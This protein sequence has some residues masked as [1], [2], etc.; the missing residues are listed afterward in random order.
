MGLTVVGTDIAIAHVSDD[1]PQI[2]KGDILKSMNG[3]EIT[4]MN[5]QAQFGAFHS[6]KP[7]DSVSFTFLRDGEEIDVELVLPAREIKHQFKV[8]EKPK[9]KQLKLREKWL[10]NA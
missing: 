4:L 9:K 3:T 8:V 10:S 5:A 6:K 2:K 7:G 1:L